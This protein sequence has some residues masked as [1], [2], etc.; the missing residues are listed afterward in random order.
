[1]GRA[2]PLEQGDLL[3][4]LSAGAYAFSM[5]SQYNTRPR[6]AEVLV[7]GQD[8]WLVRPRETIQELYAQ[9]RIPHRP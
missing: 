5:S 9:E 7:D 1:R 3:A 6:A 2:L 4:I 8:S